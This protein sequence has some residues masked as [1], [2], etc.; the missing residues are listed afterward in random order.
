M[1]ITIEVRYLYINRRAW[2]KECILRP[3]CA[4]S[5]PEQHSDRTGV[6]FRYDDVELSDTPEITDRDCYRSLPG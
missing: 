5:I 2:D 6:D 3:K 1:S 4:I